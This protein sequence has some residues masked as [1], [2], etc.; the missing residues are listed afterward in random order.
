MNFRRPP[1]G[2]RYINQNRAL[3]QRLPAV[4]RFFFDDHFEFRGHA[5][6]QL[7]GDWSFADDLDRLVELD[8]A[9]VN[10]EALRLQ[11][12]RQIGG[13]H[14]T[15]QLV[16]LAGLARELY[17][18]LV[19]QG[20]LLLGRFLFGGRTLGERDA[21]FFQALDVG[22]RSLERELL[23]QQ[24]VAGIAGG[25]F[26]DFTASSEFFD[27]FLQ[28]NLH[29]V[30]LLVV[31]IQSPSGPAVARVFRRGAFNVAQ[32]IS[33]PLMRRATKNPQVHVKV[34]SRRATG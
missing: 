33:S 9:L 12:I 17:G 32:R 20:G 2:G 8:A 24:I 21:D 5:V 26:H 28:N 14:G 3:K 25:N 34:T 10:L 19:E 16:G 18:H 13:R 31:S 1:A 22:G 6:N 27:V 7:H 11:S 30:P 29:G 4:L 15:E 23:R